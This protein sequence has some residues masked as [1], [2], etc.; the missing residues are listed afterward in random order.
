MSAIDTLLSETKHRPYDYPS[1]KW[2]YYQE[3]NNVLFF[4]WEVSADVLRPLVPKALNIDTLNG[5]AYISVVAF[6]MQ[7]IRAKNLPAIKFISDFD[8]VNVRTYIDNG[9]KKGVYFLNIEAEKPLSVFIAKALSGLPYEKANIRRTHNQYS[10]SNPKKG[11]YLDTGFDILAPVTEK[12]TLD[13]WLTERYCLYL[14]KDERLYQYDIHHKEWE[15]KNVAVKRLKLGY[16]IGGIDLT[17]RAP[18]RTH[19]SDGVKVVAWRRTKI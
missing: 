12:T 15:I 3:W 6:T 7:K 17:G 19:Y 8:E 9:H 4:H 11:F 13:H 16:K 14:N 10:S 1:G 18:D 5:K 2:T